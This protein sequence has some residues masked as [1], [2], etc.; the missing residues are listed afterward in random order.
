MVTG[1][2]T[3][4]DAAQAVR[5]AAKLLNLAGYKDV[6]ISEFKVE[7]IVASTDVLF[8]VRLENLA[9]EWK[10]FTSYEPEIFPGLVFRMHEPKMAVLIFVSGKVVFTGARDEGE[11]KKAFEKIYVVLDKFRR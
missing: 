2:R 11:V 10:T 4:A 1:A 7:N 3:P 8:P 6:K 5:K 9:N